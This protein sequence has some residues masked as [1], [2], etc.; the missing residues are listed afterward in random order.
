MLRDRGRDIEA[1]LGK[2]LIDG[3]G[4][5]GVAELQQREGCGSRADRRRGGIAVVGRGDRRSGGQDDLGGR[6]G[7]STKAERGITGATVI[8]ESDT[9][10]EAS[11]SG[12]VGA[13]REVAGTLE[14]EVRRLGHLA[15]GRAHR[16]RAVLDRKVA[17]HGIE[18][19][20]RDERL[21]ALGGR[22]GAGIAEGDLRGA[23]DG[24]DRRTDRII[25]IRQHHARIK[26]GGRGQGDHR[27]GRSDEGLS[28]RVG[29]IGA[30]VAE[31]DLG[32]A[33][34]GHDRRA[35]RIIGVIQ[36]HAGRESGRARH[37]HDRGSRRNGRSTEDTLS[38]GRRR[39]G[40]A[41]GPLQIQGTRIGERATGIG[42]VGVFR[43]QAEGG[44][45]VGDY[46]TCAH[47]SRFDD[48]G[49]P[50]NV[51]VEILR[52]A[53]N[54]VAR[55]SRRES[56]RRGRIGD[57]TDVQG[58]GRSRREGDGA[59]VRTRR[60]T[61]RVQRHRARQAAVSRIADVL[62]VR[63]R[64]SEVAVERR[65]DIPTVGVAHRH[66]TE[67]IGIGRKGAA[68]SDSPASDEIVGQTRRR[69]R[70]A[71]QVGDEDV[72]IGGQALTPKGVSAAVVIRRPP[73]DGH[74]GATGSVPHQVS[75]RDLDGA[76]FVDVRGNRQVVVAAFGRDAVQRQDRVRRTSAI[77]EETTPAHG[78]G[79]ARGDT[80]R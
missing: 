64:R 72:A 11:G 50:V 71:V 16:E 30:G 75:D 1:D 3:D 51:K 60:V 19:K 66:D 25:G 7:R 37:R 36:Y 52:C 79:V 43:T 33:V 2:A 69:E 56:G 48:N 38:D 15:R 29:E 10:Q 40:A 45:T 8:K 55:V 35:S 27:G 68:I 77:H 22:R 34:D 70:D 23:V 57:E 59:S 4:G 65:R 80:G 41:G 9:L 24:H 12:R 14:G 44:T 63:E 47:Q 76:A 54:G 62:G 67:N 28:E 58:Q 31:R 61:Q 78:N 18:G 6:R 49:A 13:E 26:A 5:V 42:I 73:R 17:R 21:S 20:R 74:A 32:G 39:E 53:R 46:R